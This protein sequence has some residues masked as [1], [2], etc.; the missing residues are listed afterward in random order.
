[1]NP[2][3]RNLR[4]TLARFRDHEGARV[5]ASIA[6]YVLFSSVPALAFLVTSV[7]WVIRDPHDQAHIVGHM[8]ELLPTG[9]EQNREAL[10]G[11][12]TAVR[13]ASRGLTVLG[14]VGLAWSSLGMFSAARWGLNRAWGVRPRAGFLRVRLMDLAA[15]GGI[16]MLLFLSATATAAIHLL[17]GEGTPL[18]ATSWLPGLAWSATQSSIPAALAFTAFLFLYRYVP[19][20]E[21]RLKDVFPA[22]LVAA[23]AFEITKHLFALYV[24]LMTRSSPL[25]AALGGILGFMLWVYLCAAIL[26][27]GAELAFV[28]SRYALAHEVVVDRPEGHDRQRKH[29]GKPKKKA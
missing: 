26:L 12:V 7:S 24:G 13:K 28:S 27:L 2:L 20:V 11:I 9:S 22:A 10:T 3:I 19:S 17:T 1:M 8:L 18:P 23:G 6:F 14:A 25:F 16:W 29:R 5:S 21:H 15:A 4:R